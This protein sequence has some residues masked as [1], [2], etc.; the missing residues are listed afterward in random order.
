MG[1]TPDLK[2]FYKVNYKTLFVRCSLKTK[3]KINRQLKKIAILNKMPK[4]PF[5][6]SLCL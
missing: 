5:D 6:C 2:S 4:I 1:Y 3:V